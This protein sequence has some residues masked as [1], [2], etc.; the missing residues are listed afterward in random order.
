M[1]MGLFGNKEDKAQQDAAAKA[2]ADR[3]VAMSAR[4]LAVDVLPAFGTGGPG[5][6]GKQIGTLGVAMYLMRDFPRGNVQAKQLI[7]PIREAFQALEHAGLIIEKVHN[8]GGSNVVITR[9]GSAAL[10]EGTVASLLT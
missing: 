3:L 6:G 2:E 4:D 5:A 8:T 10:D 9:A 7:E 1:A